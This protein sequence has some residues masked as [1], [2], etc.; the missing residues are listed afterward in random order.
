M[1]TA[2]LTAENHCGVLPAIFLSVD[3]VKLDEG[4][5]F[6]GYVEAPYRSLTGSRACVVE[7]TIPAKSGSFDA[8]D[9]MEPGVYWVHVRDGTEFKFEG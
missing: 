1:N 5:R 7:K 6:V 3:R 9:E 8:H 2:K 4:W